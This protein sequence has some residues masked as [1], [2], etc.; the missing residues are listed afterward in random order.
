[1]A[2]K[3]VLVDSVDAVLKPTRMQ[4]ATIRLPRCSSSRAS[5]LHRSTL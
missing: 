3:R 4:Q 5:P 2:L 1:M